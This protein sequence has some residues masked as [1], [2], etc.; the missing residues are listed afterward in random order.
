MPPVNRDASGSHFLVTS[1]KPTIL[2]S[3]VRVA[4]TGHRLDASYVSHS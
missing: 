3:Y 2:S 4:A 1:Q